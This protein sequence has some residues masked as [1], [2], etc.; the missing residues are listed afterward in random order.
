M[1]DYEDPEI[2]EQW[3]NE[4]RVVVAAYLQKEKVRYNDIGE[5]PAFH[6]APYLSLW[7]VESSEVLGSIGW[8]ALCGDVP[9]D[10]I[11][12]ADIEPPQHPRKA[13]RVFSENWDEIVRAWDEG[14]EAINVRLGSAKEREVLGPM[15]KTRSK[16]LLE[17]AEDDELWEE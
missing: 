10:H 5:W 1:P 8:W 12:A 11:S 3:C 13:L 2:E 7:A 4:Q 9:L 6:L 16:F 15:L 14:K 17:L